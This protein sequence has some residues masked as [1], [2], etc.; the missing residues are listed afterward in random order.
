MMIVVYKLTRSDG[1]QYIGKA[2]NFK[3]RLCQHAK[4][5]RFKEYSMIKYE[6]LEQCDTHEEALQYEKKYIEQYDTFHNGLN[7]TKD[8]SGNH[9]SPN[10]TTEGYK[11]TE[12]SKRKMSDGA[13]RRNQIKHAQFWHNNLSQ[14][15]KV[16]FYKM[17]SLK[18]K[19][20]PKSTIIKTEV[21]SD[22]LISYKN[23]IELSGVGRKQR[24]GRFMSYERAFSLHFSNKYKIS[25][26]TVI[27]II[28]NRVH[29]WKPLYERIIGT[30][31]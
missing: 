22:I 1:K 17:H 14:E 16:N 31:S 15:E 21:V 18:T 20:K 5:E 6:I 30:K 27:N 23:K 7:K 29:S 24:N 4:S 25:P 2:V 13:K 12:K 9:S 11:F 10:F 19:G 3:N 28:E 8:G 26:R